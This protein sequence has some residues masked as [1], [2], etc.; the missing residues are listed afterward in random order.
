MSR[1]LEGERVGEM[2]P[3]E[4]TPLQLGPRSNTASGLNQNNLSFPKFI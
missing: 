4:L 1:D 2:L 3:G